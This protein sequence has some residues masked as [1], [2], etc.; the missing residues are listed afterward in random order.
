MTR[1]EKMQ[2][3]TEQIAKREA[4][5]LEWLEKLLDLGRAKLRELDRATECD[6]ALRV[7]AEKDAIIA[8]LTTERK[9]YLARIWDLEAETRDSRAHIAR[10]EAD[11]QAATER[12]ERI[13]WEA[14]GAPMKGETP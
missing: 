2:A 11:A 7:L 5:A 8:T 12:V 14:R 10:M 1:D 3:M 13:T 4:V 6:E 9:G